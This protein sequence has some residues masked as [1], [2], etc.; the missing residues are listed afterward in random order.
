MSRDFQDAEKQ[1]QNLLNSPNQIN[2]NKLSLNDP[3]EAP[4]NGHEQNSGDDSDEDTQTEQATAAAP[5]A[6]A[7][8]TTDDNKPI[9][10]NE[11]DPINRR[12]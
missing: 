2:L 3:V 7:T 12:N 4:T 5:P 6:S 11:P 8:A 10:P 9:D 1:K